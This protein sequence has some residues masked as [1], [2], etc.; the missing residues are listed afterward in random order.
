M[1]RMGRLSEML[2]EAVY[3]PPSP[4]EMHQRTGM[5]L[6]KDKPVVRAVVPVRGGKAPSSQGG[7]RATAKKV[8]RRSLEKFLVTKKIDVKTGHGVDYSAGNIGRTTEM[9]SGR[10]SREG[11]EASSY[12]RQRRAHGWR[13]FLLRLMDDLGVDSL[14]EKK[15]HLEDNFWHVFWEAGARSPKKIGNHKLVVDAFLYFAGSRLVAV[16]TKK[17]DFYSFKWDKKNRNG[18][19]VGVIFSG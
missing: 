3:R 8:T 4:G 7:R 15:G 14:T 5:P 19:V 18:D 10:W 2:V 13:G 1:T 12:A 17:G 16:R 11:V 9:G 6:L